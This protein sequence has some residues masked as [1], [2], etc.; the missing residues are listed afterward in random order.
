MTDSN[1]L[2]RIWFRLPVLVRAIVGGGFVF[3]VLQ[4]GC[5]LLFVANMQVAASVPWSL[6][7]GLLYLWVV[8][9]YFNG[10]WKPRSTSFARRDSMRARRLSGR[11]WPPA[12]VACAAVVVF[13]IAT[14][15]ISYRLIDVPAEE[16]GLGSSVTAA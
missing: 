14:T 15:V 12:L 5:N 3:L 11:E 6:P 10:R 9:Q 7:L 1:P 4:T 13:I 16:M 8:F 2:L